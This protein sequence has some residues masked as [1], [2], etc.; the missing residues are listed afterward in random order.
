MYVSTPFAL[1]TATLPTKIGGVRILLP[2]GRT[3]AMIYHATVPPQGAACD[4]DTCATDAL[5]RVTFPRS[6]FDAD[7]GEPA[8]ATW[9]SC[10][11]HWP[12]FRDATLRNGHQ[13]TD[14]TGDPRR[15]PR[16]FPGWR[17]FRSDLGRLYA[18]RPGITVYG[19]LTAQLRA[20]IGAYQARERG[21]LS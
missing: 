14:A 17:I 2:T 6:R 16:E 10:D 20:E 11:L 5:V 1:L 3:E 18:A 4:R 7:G 15:L 12:V 9:D 19:W 8:Q 13:V 21:D